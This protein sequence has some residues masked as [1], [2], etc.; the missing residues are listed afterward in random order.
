MADRG[1][2][3]HRKG[4]GACVARGSTHGCERVIVVLVHAM[5]CNV[6]GAITGGLARIAHVIARCAET[7]G[8]L[9]PVR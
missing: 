1:L 2:N 7:H 9:P 4:G 6:R 8:A 5:P 3:G